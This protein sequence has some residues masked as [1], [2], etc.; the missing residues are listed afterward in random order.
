MVMCCRRTSLDP[1][2]PSSTWPS[3]IVESWVSKLEKISHTLCLN[4]N[5]RGV[6]PTCR[7][8]LHAVEDRPIVT[9]QTWRRPTSSS[10]GG[11]E[12]LAGARRARICSVL[13]SRIVKRP[14][15]VVG[16]RDRA[17]VKHPRSSVVAKRTAVSRPGRHPRTRRHCRSTFRAGSTL[18]QNRTRSRHRPRWKLQGPR[19]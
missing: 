11:R 14:A 7:M 10:C 5:L 3:T 4:V 12:G 8:V 1:Q 13:R 15:N 17:S 6:S 19:A 9:A 2:I 18:S 16:T